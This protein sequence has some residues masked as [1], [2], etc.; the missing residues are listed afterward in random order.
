MTPFD[1]LMMNWH[2][3]PRAVPLLVGAV[4][5]LGIAIEAWRLRSARG[6]IYLLISSLAVLIYSLGYAF[7]LGS[8]SIRTVYFWLK[9]EYLGVS[10]VGP[11]L[12]ALALTYTGS[13][14]APSPLGLMALLVIPLLTLIFA[15]TNE[16]H[17]LI[18]VDLELVP[19][20]DYFI[21]AFKRG[22]WYWVESVY[23]LILLVVSFGLFVRS[24]LRERGLYR[25]QLGLILAGL[26]IPLLGYVL[27]LLRL[28]PA[29]IDPSPYTLILTAFFIGWALLDYRFMDIIPVAR[30]QVLASMA[31]AI[32]V[33]DSL[34]RVVELNPAAQHLL[35]VIPREAIGVPI[36]EVL[37]PVWLKALSPYLDLREVRAEIA[38]EVQGRKRFYDLHLSPLRGGIKKSV[39]R[40]LS[41]HDISER[42]MT[43]QALQEANRRLLTLREADSD[44]MHQ[45]DIAH[46]CSAT[47]EAAKRI[48]QA[49][50]AFIGLAKG[51][52]IHIMH[53]LGD[54]PA[55]LVGSSIPLD[56]GISGRAVRTRQMVLVQDVSQDPD[57]LALIPSTHSQLTA[58]L[59][60]GDKLIGV[61]T[62]EFSHPERLVDGVLESLQ[63]LASHAA[64][65]IDNAQVYAEREKLIE[66]LDAF[67]RTTAHDLKNPLYQAIVSAEVLRDQCETLPPDERNYYLS[68]IL[69][70]TRKMQA[71]IDS[72]LLLARVRDEEIKTAPLD[73]NPIVAGAIA[74]LS[75]TAKEHKAEIIYPDDWPIA[76]GYA[77]WVEEIWANYI[78]NAIQYGG[79]PPRVE[80]GFNEPEGDTICFWV[81]DNGP[82]IS[83]EDQAKLFKPFARLD[84]SSGHGLGLSIALRIAERLGGTAGVRSEQGNGSQ[85]YFTLPVAP[86]IKATP[87]LG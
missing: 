26:S 55:G 28:I 64:V 33:V 87:D 45:F 2:L 4:L 78:S 35:S 1:S 83:P 60:A 54:F 39:G 57:Y 32:I 14:R 67:A 75:L 10:L 66:E 49:D 7:E 22:I 48:T 52:A 29:H 68:V 82:G 16:Q 69:T 23:I 3:P 73:M 9:V 70:A 44:L 40:V 25:V 76:L 30:E 84:K 11:M 36:G 62:L 8:T 63:L 17:E 74:R 19:L 53:G 46:V 81:R 34:G 42:V 41:L 85:F 37:P 21:V 47:L 56:R 12:L 51:E 71:I 38:V 65:A 72:L 5:M 50:A 59:L 20:G 15:W 86:D 24:F 43:G 79:T 27:Y 80:L 13:G 61:L 18:W 6:A 31:D 77:P 58:P